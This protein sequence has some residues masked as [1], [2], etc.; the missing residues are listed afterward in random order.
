MTDT[1]TAAPA[2]IDT[3][4]NIAHLDLDPTARAG[5]YSF[6]ADAMR[7]IIPDI[8][9]KLKLEP[10]HR[11]LDIGCGTGALLIPLS[12]LVREVVGLDHPN[13]VAALAKALPNERIS[14]IGDSF[15]SA[16]IEGQFERIVAYS[17]MQCLPTFE[18][19]KAFA[20]AA[21]ALLPSGGRLLIADFPNKD[22]QERLKHTE[23]GK[24]FEAEW[25][26][27]RESQAKVTEA[28]RLAIEELA[29]AQQLGGMTNAQICELVLA[30]REAGYE[31]FL[32]EQDPE[33]PF[34]RTRED[35]IVTRL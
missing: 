33:L 21:A 12:Y 7:R 20:L 26:Q 23:A 17:V 8:L 25:A 4:G 32:A 22:R 18:D 5:R 10:H 3:Y 35:L 19:A 28:Q 27:L 34:G 9:P 16:K 6:Q 31:A 24:K 15:P 30:L 1:D 29:K 13:V 11:L 2:S 14:L